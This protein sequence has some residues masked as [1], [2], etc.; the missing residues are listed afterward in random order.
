MEEQ[1]IYKPYWRPL[2]LCYT[3]FSTFFHHTYPF[4]WEVLAQ[5]TEGLPEAIAVTW[6]EVKIHASGILGW[7]P[8]QRTNTFT[9]I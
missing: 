7:P 3:R 9:P 2:Y 8:L 1:Y 5:V 4:G 6:T